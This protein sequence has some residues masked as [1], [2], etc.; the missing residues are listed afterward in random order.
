MGPSVQHNDVICCERNYPILSP[1]TF[2][3]S[4]VIQLES[5]QGHGNHIHKI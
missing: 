5:D 3:K 4:L 1:Q 2:C